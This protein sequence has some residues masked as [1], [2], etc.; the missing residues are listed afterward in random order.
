MKKFL[1]MFSVA[2]MCVAVA[3]CSQEEG[4]EGGDETTQGTPSSTQ[5]GLESD[6]CGKCGCCAECDDC[7]EGDTC[8]DCGYQEGTALCCAEGAPEPSDVVYC[9]GCGEEKGT[10]ACC[11]D[12]AE[13]CVGCGLHKGSPLCCVVD[14]EEGSDHEGHSHE[15]GNEA[16][17]D[18]DEG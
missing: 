16:D 13:E 18:S 11:S 15:G 1:A 9:H 14:G 17:E 8:T 12:G 3:G 4:A 5:V 6:L 10:D 2:L 7:C